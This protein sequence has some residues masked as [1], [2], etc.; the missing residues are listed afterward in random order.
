MTTPPSAQ[1]SSNQDWGQTPEKVIQAWMDCGQTLSVE[2]ASSRVWQAGDGAPVICLHGVPA[3]AFLYRKL[4]PE[5]AAQNL[6]GIA[7]DFPGMGLAERPADFDYRWSNL[8]AWSMRALEALG[9]ERYHLVVHDIG[10]PIGFEMVRLAPDRV[11]SLTALNTLARVASFKRPWSM[12]PYAWPLIGELYLASTVGPVF[13]QLMRLQ[14]VL[15]A[16][17]PAELQS[18]VHLLKRGDGGRAFLKIMRSFERTDSFEQGILQALA[19]RQFPAQVVWGEND[20][21][22]KIASK[23]EELRQVLNVKDIQAVPGKHFLQEDSPRE[24]AAAVK[25][26]CCDQSQS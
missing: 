16:V 5:L 14:G 13:E 21:A 8:A 10:G 7:F 22:L 15:T 2:G 11:M 6:R 19:K 4:L 12:E 23:G 17:P 20:P 18:Y 24:I 9:I 3:S 1:L 26:L 25:R